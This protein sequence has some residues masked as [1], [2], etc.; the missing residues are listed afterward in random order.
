MVQFSLRKSD[1]PHP[2][3]MATAVSL[4][5]FSLLGVGAITG[6]I[7][8][9]YSSSSGE[10]QKNRLSNEQSF[11]GQDSARRSVAESSCVN[12][13]VVDAIRAVQVDGNASGLGAVAGGVTGAVVGHQIGN[14]HGRDAMTVIGG[15]GG[16]FAGHSI[17]KKINR[18][19]VY[20]VTVRMD[21]GSFR[22]VSQS[23][24]PSVAIGSKVRVANGSLVAL[25]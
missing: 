3:I 8:S 6:L 4:I 18:H 21:D 14:G 5:T 13:G 11:S 19:T 15:V 25:S 22:T 12:C 23:H 17:E 10:M 1:R 9:A 20:R 2:V 16:A 24:E 7:P